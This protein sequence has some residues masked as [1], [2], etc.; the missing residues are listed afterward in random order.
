MWVSI[1]WTLAL[2]ESRH[3]PSRSRC[4]SANSRTK[5]K[6][7]RNWLTGSSGLGNWTTK[8]EDNQVEE[9]QKWNSREVAHSPPAKDRMS[10]LPAWYAL[11]H[12]SRHPIRRAFWAS[13]LRSSPALGQHGTRIR[14]GRPC[15]S[16]P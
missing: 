2:Y 11:T 10:I 13:V 7:A 15:L 16:H 4:S 6:E 3:T 14:S 1:R 5:E 12:C 8:Y 9:I